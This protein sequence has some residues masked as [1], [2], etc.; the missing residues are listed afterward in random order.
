MG[1][2][3]MLS[4]EDTEKL[5]ADALKQSFPDVS[6]ILERVRRGAVNILAINW[7]DGPTRNQVVD[8]TGDYLGKG[9][10]IIRFRRNDPDDLDMAKKF[11]LD[12]WRPVPRRSCWIVSNRTGT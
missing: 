5:I 6:F 9:I 12:S 3:K 1:Q 10:D 8:M 4:F 11:R 7:T 2:F